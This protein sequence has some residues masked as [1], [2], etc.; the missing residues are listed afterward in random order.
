MCND[1]PVLLNVYD[2][3]SLFHI[4]LMWAVWRVWTTYFYNE[5]LDEVHFYDWNEVVLDF[6]VTEVARRIG[7]A[8]PVVQWLDV[9]KHRHDTEEQGE[10]RMPEKEFLIRQATAVKAN[11]SHIPRGLEG[12]EIH[13]EIQK[14][15]GNSYLVE[16][17]RHYH[18]PRLRIKYDV[19]SLVCS[20]QDEG[21]I[22]PLAQMGQGIQQPLAVTE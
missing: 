11:L 12:E 16:V 20:P 8:I 10:K 5:D 2:P 6:F 1:V 4:S 3:V 7:E 22:P 21:I 13:P 17:N 14:W 18:R 19:L 15:I 9:Y